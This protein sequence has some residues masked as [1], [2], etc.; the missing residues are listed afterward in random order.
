MLLEMQG[1]VGTILT[2]HYTFYPSTTLWSYSYIM[3][4]YTI[5]RYIQERQGPKG[6]VGLKISTVY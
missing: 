4:W 1:K 3:R 5:A 2:I 6:L